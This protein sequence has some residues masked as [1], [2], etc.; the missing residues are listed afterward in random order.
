MS[1][2]EKVEQMVDYI[3]K[4]CLWQFHSRSWDREKQ[5]AG[6]LG[7]TRELLCDQP[8][9]L[10]TPADRCYWV[11]AM[12]LADAWRAR[13]SW[14]QSMTIEAIA[15]LMDALHQRLDYLTI[16]GSLNAELTDKRY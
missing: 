16:T 3:M 13:F 5:N 15:E 14:L 2:D 6:V 1:Q 4:N 8:V 12:V 11:D 7:K 10:E 9:T